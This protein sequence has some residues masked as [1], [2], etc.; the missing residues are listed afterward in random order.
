MSSDAFN[1]SRIRTVIAVALTANF[2]LVDGPGNVLVPARAS[3]L[4]KDS[5]AHV[6]QLVTLDKEFLTDLAGRI[7]GRLLSDVESGLRLVLSV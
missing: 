7:K 3:G 4:P 5:V 1:R 6:S 2:R